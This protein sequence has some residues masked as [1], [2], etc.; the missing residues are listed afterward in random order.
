M[1]RV[2]LLSTGC[3]REGL[4]KQNNIAGH[5]SEVMNSVLHDRVRAVHTSDRKPNLNN[6]L[7][8][9]HD[10]EFFN[11]MKPVSRSTSCHNCGLHGSRRCSQCHQT[12]Y[13][14]V[15]CQKDDWKAHSLIC[16]PL[17]PKGPNGDRLASG[18]GETLYPKPTP[19]AAASDFRNVQEHRRITL[20]DLQVPALTEGLEIQGYVVEFSSPSNFF[21]QFYNAKS[22]ENLT[23]VSES[24]KKI[25]SNPE[26]VKK[27]YTPDIG[28]VCVG[29]FSKDQ[30]WYRVLVHN[31]QRTMGAAQ[32]LYIDY[33]NTETLNLGDLQPMHKEVELLPP[34]AVKCCLADVIA[35]PFGWSPECLMD[36]KRFLLGQPLSFRIVH[37]VKEE[38]PRY[39]VDVW[40]PE[41]GEHIYKIM[42]EKGYSFIPPRRNHEQEAASETDP[43]VGKLPEMSVQKQEQLC[44]DLFPATPKIKPMSFSVGERFPAYITVIQHPGIFF[45]QRVQNAK[46][47]GEITTSMNE[48]YSAA[49]M[50]PGFMPAQEEVCAAQFT[51]D[52]KWYRAI[53]V[54][55]LHDDSVVVGYLDFGNG[56]LLH[57]SRLR[58]LDPDMQS[59]P[60]QASQCCLA[61]VTPPSGTWTPKATELLR[62]LAMDKIITATVVSEDSGIVT[63]DL[64]DESTTPMVSVSKRLIEAGLA[65]PDTSDSKSPIKIESSLPSEP[66]AQ[67]KWAELPLH[68]AAEVVICMLQNPGEFCCHICNQ[69][70]LSLLNELNVALGKYC[71][72]NTADYYMPV[73]EEVCA[74]FYA[75]DG[76]W[77]RG[78]VK[79]ITPDRVIKFLFLDY[80]NIEDVAVE[81]LCKLPSNFLELPFQAICCSLAGVKP[82]GDQ[83]DKQAAETFQKSAVGKKLQATAVGRTKQTYRVELVTCDSA[84]VVADV[85]IAA[86]VAARDD[87]KM[88]STAMGTNLSQVQQR[89]DKV[90]DL[91]KSPIDPLIT[92]NMKLHSPDYSLVE[93]VALA[94]ESHRTTSIKSSAEPSPTNCTL[95]D[96][97]ELSSSK[98]TL[99]F[100][101]E[102]LS[103]KAAP[104]S[105][106]NSPVVSPPVCRKL[107][108]LYS[109]A[110]ANSGLR[111]PSSTLSNRQSLVA[112]P[113]LPRDPSFDRST[114]LSPG[115]L[116]S[117][118]SSP[119]VLKELRFPKAPTSLPR[120][121]YTAKCS[122]S[123]ST[124]STSST[125]K[126]LP[127]YKSLPAKED[128]PSVAGETVSF[129]DSAK[130]P[131]DALGSS[132]ACAARGWQSVDLPVNEALPACV[133]SVISPDLLYVF[134]KE[135]RVDVGKLQQV[136]VDIYNYCSAETGQHGYRPEVGD[137]CCAK[138]T[139]DGHW[140]RA[141]VLDVS[142]STA[143]IAY[144]DYGNMESLPLSCLRPI[145]EDFLNP[146]MPI[147]KCR[148]ADVVPVTERWSPEATQ[149]LR[150]IL[151]GADV[152]ITVQAVTDGTYSV[153]MEKLQETGLI[154]LDEKLVTAGLARYRTSTPVTSGCPGERDGCCCRDLQKRVE[155][156]ELVLQH[157]LKEEKLK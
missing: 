42:L 157:L 136:M 52:N 75:G 33:G 30:Q 1:K 21:V 35:P 126:E 78:Q 125:E 6:S 131:S 7:A 46:Q 44:K 91:L 102:L 70:D 92:R 53:V 103:T 68:Q 23:K 20:R 93:K 90:N 94:E 113:P 129:S 139:A 10:P 14:S 40:I 63:L 58:P 154:R 142:E 145:K 119:P 3:P 29:K 121:L 9:G 59:A 61:G 49:P 155:K 124:N 83:W 16:K 22:L 127:S 128:V 37:L 87:S 134:P 62:V 146:P 117:P 8:L 132:G 50:T 144:A 148:I 34:N 18:E 74:A 141:V 137:A 111:A 153:S 77:Y 31:L 115:V 85:L 54:K 43:A 47:L 133:L 108:S 106:S 56:E 100:Q 71:V 99:S 140:Y 135:N 84:A 112:S 65:V 5:S 28:E 36:V 122:L 69:T 151:V 57:M 15:E 66:S 101:R 27:G 19:C 45:C 39:A 11:M 97:R 73:K 86:G 107:H 89:T 95:P 120:E 80:G 104:T 143:N 48:R 72:Q 55:R 149:A 79:D 110:S 156:L 41:S 123:T 64:I 13:C 118:I 138:F 147:T 98:S 4:N 12:Y 60:C 150:A 109:A 32:V 67:L 152:S 96:D 2:G 26:N 76:N 130:K 82:L 105:S 38:L 88:D 51:E 81:K 116:R 114:P 17:M 25:Y 24:L